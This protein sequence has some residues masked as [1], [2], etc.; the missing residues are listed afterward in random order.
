MSPPDSGVKVLCTDECECLPDKVASKT[1]TLK[2]E[3]AIAIAENK[4][5]GKFDS[6]AFPAPS[7]EYL[8]RQDGSAA[9]T[10]VLQV[11]N[12]ENH[13]WYEAFVDAHSG[14]VVS[15]TDFKA[16]ASVSIALL[17]FMAINLISFPIS[18]TASSR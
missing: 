5:G 10:Y 11:R 17:L 2:A 18:S 12:V 3:D 14:D 15:V 16:H 1:P 4:L 13:I 9:L 6:A 7:L 8:A